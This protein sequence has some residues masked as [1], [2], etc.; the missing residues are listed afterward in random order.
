MTPGQIVDLSPIDWNH[1]WDER[2]YSSIRREHWMARVFWHQNNFLA[3]AR[4]ADFSRTE[5]E[6]YFLA[7]EQVAREN[8]EPFQLR[9]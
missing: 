8:E 6:A 3:Q 5:R 2:A 4:A 9:A 7:V 1:R